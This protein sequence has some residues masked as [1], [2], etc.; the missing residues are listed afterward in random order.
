MCGICGRQSVRDAEWRGVAEPSNFPQSLLRSDWGHTFTSLPPHCVEFR[1]SARGR[2]RRGA[3]NGSFP[4]LARAP[5]PG[6]PTS[7][8]K[9]CP[10]LEFRALILEAISRDRGDSG[11]LEFL[12]KLGKYAFQV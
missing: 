9:A 10:V 7:L 6:P 5:G 3:R 4:D 2:L 12:R 8:R 11:G 1:G